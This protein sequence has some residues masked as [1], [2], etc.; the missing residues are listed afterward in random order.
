VGPSGPVPVR[1]LIRIESSPERPAGG[2]ESALSDDLDPVRWN[3]I[4]GRRRPL[5]GYGR[6]R[7]YRRDDEMTA[8]AAPQH[9]V[10]VA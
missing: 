10:G 5:W 2:K 8:E 4:A 7:S 9:V 1:P 6:G 3:P